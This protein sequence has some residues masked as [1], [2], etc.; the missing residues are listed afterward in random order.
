MPGTFTVSVGRPILSVQILTDS[1]RGAGLANDEGVR[2][3][4][5]AEQAALIRNLEKQKQEL[6]LLLSTLGELTVKLND[7]Y[8]KAFSEHKAEIAKLSLEIARKVIVQKVKKGDYEM[9]SIIQEA[10]NNAPTR[11]DVVVR[12]NPQDLAG[13]QKMQQDKGSDVFAGI[14]FVGDSNIGRAECLLETPKG[15]I[16]S[17]IDKHLE[18]IGKALEKAE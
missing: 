1:A 15:I 3:G 9:E 4:F 18:Q 8:N 10:L 6:A 7:F 5:D 16:E 12:L 2:T 11:E 17:L 14:K 13:L